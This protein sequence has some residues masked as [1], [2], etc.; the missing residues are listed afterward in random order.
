MEHLLGAM[1]GPPSHNHP[2]AGQ[3]GQTPGQ[4]PINPLA[5]IFA[6]LMNPGM[7]ASGDFVY[8]QEALDRVISNLMEQN[9]TGNAPGPATPE[10]IN[11]LARKTITMEDLGSDGRAECSICMDEVT[12]GEEVTQ[13]PCHHWFHQQC[14]AMW[15][16]EHD[17]CPHCRKG[18]MDH[19]KPNENSNTSSNPAATSSGSTGDPASP[20][21]PQQ[22]MPGAFGSGTAEN[23]FIVSETP[24]QARLHAHQDQRPSRERQPSPHSVH[25]DGSTGRLGDRIRRGLFG[26]R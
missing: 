19:D 2:P 17:T 5:A 14:V 11:A 18:I 20:S 3:P 22:Q 10:A 1:G 6:Q 4:P 24:D 8:S 13:L 26:P 23:P 25:S 21:H 15:L 9:A 16:G 12:V 7:A